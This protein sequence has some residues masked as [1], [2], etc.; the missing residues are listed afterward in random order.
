[1]SKKFI[2]LISFVLAL[3]LAGDVQAASPHFSQRLILSGFFVAK[4]D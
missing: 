1:M 2:Y 4:E 3:S